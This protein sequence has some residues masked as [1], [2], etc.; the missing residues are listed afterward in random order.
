M[1]RDISVGVVGTS[2]WTEAMYLPSLTS[3]PHARI[4][5]ICGRGRVRAEALASAWN[6]GAVHTDYRDLLH[7]DG[8]EAVIVATPD[9]LHPEMTLAA[10]GRG[11]HVMCEK[12]L[13]NSA[14]E[15]REMAAAAEAAGVK[16]MV[17]FTWQF[18]PQHRHLRRLVES[19]EIGRVHQM[20]AH[21]IADY[22]RE[23][24]YQWRFDGRR[25]NG[26]LGDLGSHLIDL[27]RAFV[28]EVESVA[29]DLCQVVDRA[30]LPGPAATP[31]NDSGF[32]LLRS[33]NGAQG[34]LHISAAS[35]GGDRDARL[36]ITLHGD[37]GTLESE[38]VFAGA[39]TGSTLR[40]LDAGGGACRPLVVSAELL[41]GLTPEA[42]PLAAFTRLSIGPRRFVDAIL[43]DLPIPTTFRD[44]AR[45]QAVADA[46]LRADRER[47][48][49]AV[50]YGGVSP[51]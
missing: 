49:I 3:H 12:P 14:A 47:R 32:V 16:H 22:A 8:L 2:W 23:P 33:A 41:D 6:I 38:C 9:D 19:G 50:D 25:A 36:G 39:E 18:L 21:F 7:H 29:A 17:L 4:A 45:A 27:Y 13:A 37:T 1:R 28:G 48:W 42:D 40:A 31:A 24:V 11:L 51:P 44:G 26:V 30:G 43:D 10:L 46:A 5:A 15:A 20:T 34:V 35:P